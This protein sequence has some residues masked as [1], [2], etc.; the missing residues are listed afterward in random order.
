MAYQTN[1]GFEDTKSSEI[2]DYYDKLEYDEL[3][4]IEEYERQ[5]LNKNYKEYDK[6]QQLIKNR[7][8]I[9]KN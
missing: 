9:T 1:D 8:K 6:K 3:K 5:R 2:K 7:K 4:L